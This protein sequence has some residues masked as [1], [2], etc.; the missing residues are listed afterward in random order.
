MK[1]LSFCVLLS[2][3]VLTFN[4]NQVLVSLWYANIRIMDQFVCLIVLKKLHQ[5]LWLLPI[6][7]S[8]MYQECNQ[9]KWEDFVINFHWVL[10]FWLHI[11]LDFKVIFD[12][13]AIFHAFLSVVPH[14][15]LAH[16]KF[17]FS[18]RTWWREPAWRCVRKWQ[19]PPRCSSPANSRTCPSGGSAV[20]H[21]TPATSQSW[22]CQQDTGQVR[23]RP[24]PTLVC[25]IKTHQPPHSVL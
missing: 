23:S 8:A 17:S 7:L 16:L 4:L 1:L 20:R 10:F 2:D 6:Q 18:S 12:F 3:I 9:R 22:M 24:A 14:W 13:S 5:D 11:E 25:V 19:T 21:L 15:L